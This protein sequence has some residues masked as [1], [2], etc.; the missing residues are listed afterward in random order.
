MQIMFL[1]KSFFYSF[2]NVINFIL[3]KGKLCEGEGSQI[4]SK[5]KHLKILCSL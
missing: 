3:C 1:D 5:A 4:K 2:L